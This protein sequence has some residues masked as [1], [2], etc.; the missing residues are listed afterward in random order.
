MGLD[1]YVWEIYGIHL[2]S[3]PSEA[4]ETDKI[5]VLRHSPDHDSGVIGASKSFVHLA[6]LMNETLD[7]PLSG[8]NPIGLNFDSD[9]REFCL[10]WNIPY[11][12]PEWRIFSYISY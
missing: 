9:I 3:I 10:Q 6:N 5:M 11:K 7:V 2:D 1:V 12:Q 4:D 8:W